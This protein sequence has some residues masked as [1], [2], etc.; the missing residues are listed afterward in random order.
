MR[1][2]RLSPEADEWAHLVDKY[3]RYDGH[4]ATPEPTMNA[5]D[6]PI[7]RFK[8]DRAVLIVV[9]IQDK[10]FPQM[11]ALDDL[12]QRIPVLIQG[13]QALKLPIVV[14]EQYPKGLGTTARPIRE[15]LGEHYVPIEKT[16]FSCLGSDQV[17]EALNEHKAKGRDQLIVCG[18]E[19]HVCVLQTLL[20]AKQAGWHTAAVLDTISSRRPIDR[21]TAVRRLDQNG[22]TLTTTESILFELMGHSKVD[23]FKTIS[24]LVKP[25]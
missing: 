12:L 4:A 3:S 13:C 22:I 1:P 24:G 6:N 11:I 21:E 25:L 17:K 7:L 8:P 5:P 16:A 9:D 14:T 19:A 10:L 15:V 23:A 18:I 2:P 20:D